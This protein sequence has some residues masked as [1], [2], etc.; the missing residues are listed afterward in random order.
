MLLVNDSLLSDY[1]LTV[2]KL[3]VIKP[4][5][6]KSPLDLKNYHPVSDLS[7]MSKVIKQRRFCS[8][9]SPAWIFITCLLTN[10][11]TAL[12]QLYSKWRTAFCLLWT[13]AM[14][15]SLNPPWSVFCFWYCWPRLSLLQTS[16]SLW[17]F[18]H[19]SFVVGVTDSTQT[20][21]VNGRT[22]RP[23]DIFF[24]VPPGSVLGPDL[25]IPYSAPLG[26]LTETQSVSNQSC[27]WH[28]ADWQHT[29][30]PR[31]SHRTIFPDNE[32]ASLHV[33]NADMLAILVWWLQITWLLKSQF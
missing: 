31:K 23:A 16:I 9:F 22:L 18:W 20:V 29:G 8:T 7:F 28:T 27:W 21:T 17:H 11:V 12:P 19:C 33:G 2:F 26:S 25:F 15:L 10:H 1:F 14:C 32:P 24:G 4:L 3:T 5:L 13:L 6:Q 30:S